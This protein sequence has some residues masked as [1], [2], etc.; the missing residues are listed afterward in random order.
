MA[1]S[2]SSRRQEAFVVCF[3]LIQAAITIALVSRKRNDEIPWI[4]APS[5]D[6]AARKRN[7]TDLKDWTW[8]DGNLSQFYNKLEQDHPHLDA[9][10]VNSY[11][12][13]RGLGRDRSTT[14]HY[15]LIHEAIQSRGLKSPCLWWTLGVVWGLV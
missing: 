12:V 8:F 7:A 10:S 13:H 6:T 2:R 5:V 3:F 14:E 4:L 15:R 9:A 1:K 11:A